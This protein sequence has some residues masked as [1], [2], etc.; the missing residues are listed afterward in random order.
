MH[1]ARRTVGPLHLHDTAFRDGSAPSS[2]GN[3]RRS[4]LSCPPPL[5]RLGP[6]RAI[7]LPWREREWPGAELL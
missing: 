5:W 3:G 4:L 6:R 1:T 2:P 7:A